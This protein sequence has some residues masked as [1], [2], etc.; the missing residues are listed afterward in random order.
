MN[1]SPEKFVEISEGAVQASREQRRL[2]LA[3]PA[4]LAVCIKMLTWL[5]RQATHEEEKAKTE[6]FL[7]LRDA[8]IHDAKNHRAM[9]EEIRKS[10][11]AKV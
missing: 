10:L 4:M 7:T 9:A 6:R 2:E 5:E 3:A 1:V 8:Y 11:P